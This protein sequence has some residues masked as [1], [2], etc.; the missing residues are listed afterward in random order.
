MRH[1]ASIQTITLLKPIKDA[2]K[3]ETALINGWECVVEKNK[4]QAGGTAIYIEIDSW[5]PHEIAPFLSKGK[6]PREYNGIKG[7]RL[8]TVKLRGQISQGILLPVDILPTNLDNPNTRYS[9][10]TDVTNLLNIQKY[11]PPIPAQIAGTI[12]G[13]FPGHV[14]KT[15]EER[16]QN[17]TQKIP[18]YLAQKLTFQVTEKL[19]GASTT[20]FLDEDN[21]FHV[22][23]RNWSLKETQ[24]NTPW[25]IARELDIEQKMKE[26]HL[27]NI[28]LQGELIG[29]NIQGNPYK[30]QKCRFFGFT[31]FDTKKGCRIPPNEAKT[32]FEN[33]KIL[34]VPILIDT[35]TI[36]NVEN[37]TQALLA[38]A[39]GISALNPNT[40]R[41]GLVWKCNETP[42]I[43]FKT[44][45]NNYLLKSR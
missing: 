35:A 26:H 19:D 20:Y 28:A 10:G 4:F 37:P 31:V 6:P 11:E 22:C 1:L 7:E 15:D 25:R 40:K 42:S 30:L 34:M 43:H 44:I 13:K 3:I 45:S 36:P 24:T 5:V 2:D 38:Y 12:K 17:I 33:L 14:E 23:T 16:I 29:P 18:E 41:E 27:Q 32:I 21:T 39:D 8:T 9:P